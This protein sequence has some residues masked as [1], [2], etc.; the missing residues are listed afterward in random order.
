[1]CVGCFVL[2][3][4]DV[5]FDFCCDFEFEQDGEDVEYFIFIGGI[6]LFCSEFFVFG[7]F[8]IGKEVWVDEFIC[9]QQY[10]GL[11]EEGDGEDCV[12]YC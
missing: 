10:E 4:Y 9:E 5:L 11:C 7:C 1:M 12:Y 2:V 8:D 6:C 3:V